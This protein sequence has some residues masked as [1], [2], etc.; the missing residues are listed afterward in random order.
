MQV[1]SGTESR[2]TP[3]NKDLRQV[4]KSGGNRPQT[5]TGISE[6]VYLDSVT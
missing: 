3:D 4:D 1:R 5:A 6:T 2:L